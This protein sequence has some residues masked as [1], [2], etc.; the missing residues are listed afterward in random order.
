[1]VSGGKAGTVAQITVPF[2]AHNHDCC[3][4]DA[5]E[6]AA[7]V[8]AERKLRLTPARR[9]MIA[10]LWR[11]H[12][13]MTR[14]ELLSAAISR[15]EIGSEKSAV[16]ALD[17]LVVNGFAHK[18]PGQS[19]Y[20][21]C[22]QPDVEHSANL[23]H[24]VECG[25]MRE[26]RDDV[27][28]ET[29]DRALKEVRFNASSATLEVEGICSECIEKC[30]SNCRRRTTG[31]RRGALVLSIAQRRRHGSERYS[32]T[33]LARPDD[34]DS[35]LAPHHPLRA[36]GSIANTLLVSEAQCVVTIS[37]AAD[38]LKPPRPVILK[39]YLAQAIFGARKRAVFHDRLAFDGLFRWFV[40]VPAS[41]SW[42]ADDFLR[43]R[44][45]VFRDRRAR[46]FFIAFFQDQKVRR[47]L[48][49]DVFDLD[50]ELV[51]EL[52]GIG[53]FSSGGKE[54]NGAHAKWG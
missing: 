17:F 32:T 22:V 39:S 53:R 29:L 43:E 36:I 20:L 52:T 37:G 31:D 4:A 12:R 3:V 33:E 19:A 13:P 16:R 47:L 26:L 42:R 25:Q 46:A 14:T 38:G 9:A 40:G 35:R 5:L 23:L 30:E 54:R 24:C 28:K 7:R 44:A 18:V 10:L 11:E 6:T 21:G 45:K 1:M 50:E 51:S 2:G 49:R 48:K 41:A 15:Q 8:C 27:L 34:V